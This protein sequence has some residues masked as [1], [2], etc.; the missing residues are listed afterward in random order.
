MAKRQMPAQQPATSKQDYRT[1]I[2]LL[3][4]VKRRLGINEFDCDL[5]ADADNTVADVYY[6]RETNALAAGNSWKQGNGWN[7]LN[8]E[9]GMIEPFVKK[10]W[11][12]STA[13]QQEGG[14]VCNYNGAKTVVLVP[15]GVGANWWRDYVHNKANVVFLNGR[16]CFI[17]DWETQLFGLGEAFDKHTGEDLVGQRKFPTKPLYPKDCA[18]L[19]YHPHT[20]G[21]YDVWT[22]RA[23]P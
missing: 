21:S 5:A 16:L 3:T 22:W 2:E 15:A 19:W 13:P 23:K 10:A 7:W 9:F 6:D 18:L 17:P 12:E 14:G 20:I 4:A 1:E 8:P 11:Q